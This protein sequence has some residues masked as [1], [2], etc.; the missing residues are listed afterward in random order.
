MK[1]GFLL[2]S[3]LFLI[4]TAGVFA[5]VTA[6][7]EGGVVKVTWTYTN[8]DATFVGLVGDFQGWNL[9]GAVPMT[10]DANGV[11]TITLDATPTSEFKYKFNVDDEWTEDP[12]APA[13]ADDGFGGTNGWVIVSEL[14]AGAASGGSGGGTTV[15]RGLAYGLFWATWGTLGFATEN[16]I[17]TTQKGFEL[18]TVSVSN[19][20]YFKFDGDIFPGLIY[21]AGE[22]KLFDGPITFF[23]KELVYNENIAEFEP[24]VTTTA[25]EG[26]YALASLP[27]TF[28]DQ[29][30]A[31]WEKDGG[32]QGKFRMVL[33]LKDL[34]TKIAHSVGWSKTAKQNIEGGFLNVWGDPDANAGITEI[35]SDKSIDLG[36]LNLDY[37]LNL[38]YSANVYK[39]NLAL[40]LNVA[41]ATVLAGTKLDTG[42]AAIDETFAKDL[43]TYSF[44]DVVYKMDAIT[45]MAAFSYATAATELT[46]PMFY[47]VG[48]EYK[49][50]PL[51][52][53]VE[54]ASGGKDSK[55]ED[56]SAVST[57]DLDIT[58]SLS[59]DIS[60]ML[61]NTLKADDKFT[62]STFTDEV[63]VGAS[64]KVDALTLTPEVFMAI[65]VADGAKFDVTKITL[66][67]AYDALKANVWVSATEL[68]KT[69]DIRA[70]IE[71]ALNSDSGVSLGLSALLDEVENNPF[72][73]TLGYNLKTPFNEMK[74]PYFFAVFDYNISAMDGD[75][76]F[77]F[78][79]IDGDDFK[80]KSGSA[81]RFGLRWNF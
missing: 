54:F 57:V 33:T 16:P 35:Y 9:G 47:G 51:T 68:F 80:I 36:G 27:W 67:A 71:Y 53:A 65:P 62:A 44:L 29:W 78:G 20:A 56:Y 61:G 66:G 31:N 41:G 19:K 3:A 30:G 5:K 76:N 39:S 6:V 59:S 26:L 73:V 79:D 64:V 72:G 40:T 70:S 37:Y 1:K 32:L 46:G 38:D 25:Q 74:N 17:K 23:K 69:T 15:V 24:E 48:V 12:E 77:V 43:A 28:F 10:K 22:I 4:A 7:Q 2:F 52:V 11:W 42:S 49:A 58:Y 21:G 18:D 45:A 81:L 75:D 13:G 55:V 8:A 14:L 34:N 60:I 63:S 50:A